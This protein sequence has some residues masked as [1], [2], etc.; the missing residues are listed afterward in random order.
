MHLRDILKKK[1]VGQLDTKFRVADSCMASSAGTDKTVTERVTGLKDSLSNDGVHCTVVGYS[2]V[3]KNITVLVHELASSKT[4][5]NLAD[6][7]SASCGV[8][9]FGRSHFW[10]GITSP[11]GSTKSF[12][13]FSAHKQH[14]DRFY[15]T[16]SPYSWGGGRGGGR[17]W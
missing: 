14:R 13:A 10:R 8:S 5:K 16:T 17:R 4:G 3:A 9:G 11:V 15:K 7:H 2:N 12:H 6:N 1:L